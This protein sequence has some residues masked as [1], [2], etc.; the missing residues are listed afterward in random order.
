MREFVK[1]MGAVS[2]LLRR[3]YSAVWT[4]SHRHSGIHLLHR[5][6]RAGWPVYWSALQ[7]VAGMLQR[8]AVHCSMH[9][10]RCRAGWMQYLDAETHVCIPRHPII[11][12]EHPSAGQHI[13]ASKYIHIHT[14]ICM[15]I[16]S[17]PAHAIL[18]HHLLYICIYVHI[19]IH[20]L[21]NIH[22]YIYTY[23]HK[24]THT[25]IYVYVCK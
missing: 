17:V 5:R 25:N 14:W 18:R 23:I 20:T 24:Y 8:V 7:C 1:Q 3:E 11:H 6:H 12:S 15:Y 21:K 13:V 10:I 4:L 22:V 2:H 16:Y 19:C 9:Q